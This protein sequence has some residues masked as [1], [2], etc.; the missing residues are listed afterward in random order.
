MLKK[1][2]PTAKTFLPLQVTRTVLLKNGLYM[3]TKILRKWH[4]N[5]MRTK[6]QD[7]NILS[8]RLSYGWIKV[9]LSFIAKQCQCVLHNVKVFF[10]FWNVCPKENPRTWNLIRSTN[11]W[12]HQIRFMCDQADVQWDWNFTIIQRGWARWSPNNTKESFNY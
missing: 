9:P 7:G 3:N 10:N 11:K 5:S 1:Q 2:L 4:L 12:C 6:H 8:L